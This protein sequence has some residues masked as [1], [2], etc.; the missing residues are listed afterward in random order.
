MRTPS[1]RG[2]RILL[3]AALLLGWTGCGVIVYQASY[4]AFSGT[5]DNPGNNWTA[6]TVSL[7][8]DD[9]NGAMFTVPAAKGGDTGTKCIEVTYG[10]SL[11]ANV[12]LYLADADLADN[13]LGQYI[14]LTIDE[15]DGGTFADCTGF[16]G[17]NRWTG[18]LAAFNS[19]PHNT[20]ATG[21]GTFA[22]AA[23]GDKKVY[24]FGYTVSSAAGA[25]GTDVTA[26]FTW[27]AQSS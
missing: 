6:G 1:R 8:D 26:T 20:F 14:T 18:T 9:S 23:P 2:R 5:T 24:K 21:I 22:P 4:A 11:A 12:K 19:T 25:Q 15:G 7:T 10:G 17:T 27:E 16:V 3:V 13:G